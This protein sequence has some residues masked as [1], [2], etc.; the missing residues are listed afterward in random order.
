MYLRGRASEI[1]GNVWSRLVATSSVTIKVSK[2][3]SEYV[4]RSWKVVNFLGVVL[5]VQFQINITWFYMFLIF[6]R[7]M[8]FLSRDYIYWL[9]IGQLNAADS[10]IIPNGFL[11]SLGMG[12]KWRSSISRLEP[13]ITN[14]FRPSRDMIMT[15]SRDKFSSN[16]SFII[17][18]IPFTN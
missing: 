1:T 14:H 3:K 15:S 16:S 18:F 11:S 4:L 5:V 8:I 2:L 12:F 6:L 13:L 10:R 7:K 9:M 17:C